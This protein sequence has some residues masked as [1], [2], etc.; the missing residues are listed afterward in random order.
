MGQFEEREVRSQPTCNKCA[1]YLDEVDE[2]Y[3]GY[4]LLGISQEDR[5]YILENIDKYE[6]DIP[7]KVYDLLMFYMHGCWDWCE[8]ARR[9]DCDDCCQFFDLH[10]LYKRAIE[11][12][13][14]AREEHKD[15]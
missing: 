4:C 6:E 12:G 13:T 1:H 10:P 7:D 14:K 9:V 11:I 2:D 15:A 8:S 3:G 5:D